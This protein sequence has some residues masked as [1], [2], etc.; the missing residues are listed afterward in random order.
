MKRILIIHGPNL[1]YLGSR[2]VKIYGKATL[3]DIEKKLTQHFSQY[4]FYFKQSNCEGQ[5]VTWIQNS[6]EENFNGILFNLGAYSHSSI[7]LCDTL[8]MISIP[9]IEIHISN[10]Y[11][12]D[13]FRQTLITAPEANGIIIGLG[14]DSY[15]VGMY[16][17]NRIIH[18][19]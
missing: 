3:K 13:S 17:L 10:V 16:A 18:H 7:A 4:S 11:R 9:K 5:L 14:I 2:Q 19:P 8:A 1:N 15:I 6:Q 12:R